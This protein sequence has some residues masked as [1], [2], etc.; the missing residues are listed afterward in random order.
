M[1][2]LIGYGMKTEKIDA[3]VIREAIDDTAMPESGPDEAR[4]GGALV[5]LAAPST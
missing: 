3:F 5:S 4:G 2:L 1:S